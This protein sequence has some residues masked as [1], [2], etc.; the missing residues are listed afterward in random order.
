MSE[1]CF[2]GI[3][4]GGTKCAGGVLT[5]P[6]GR[7]LARRV[8]PTLPERGGEAVL[9]DVIELCRTLQA[10]AR[11]QGYAPAAIGID[12]A[13]MVDLDGQVVS[14][15][16]IG[17]KDVDVAAQVEHETKLATRI[18]ADVR[19]AARAEAVLGAGRGL[20][21]FLYVTVGTGISCSLVLD[22]IPYAGAR[23]LTGTFASG[24]HLM[25]DDRGHLVW[26]AP[27][28]EFASGPALARRMAAMR[29]G[30]T[31]TAVEV[32]ALANSG[33]AL[34]EFIVD[35][36]SR[37]LGAA[38][39]QLVNVLDPEV[40]VIGGGLGLAAGLYREGVAAGVR[41]FVWSEGHRDVPLVS[42]ELG[43]D[44]GWIGAAV[45]APARLAESAEGTAK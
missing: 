16:T 24:R 29:P 26:G 1:P 32:L 21:T 5:L 13:E 28:E 20:S 22:A 43:A 18:D 35:T 4:V 14:E 30:F 7:V 8:Q 38:I 3:D 31:G 10:E 17:W 2:I 42:A 25:A 34:A 23:G 37:A 19:A 40:V 12:V 44:A 9:V 11:A 45:G 6:E 33:D 27:L 39:A 41:D 15:A 36:G